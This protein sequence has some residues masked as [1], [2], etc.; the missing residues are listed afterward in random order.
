MNQSRDHCAYVC[1]RTHTHVRVYRAVSACVRRDMRDRIY[2]REVSDS[3][4]G[5]RCNI[6]STV[7]ALD[8]AALVLKH[9]CSDRVETD[10]CFAVTSDS[11]RLSRNSRDNRETRMA[12]LTH[13]GTVDTGA[14]AVCRWINP[15]IPSPLMNRMQMFVRAILQYIIII[16]PIYYNYNYSFVFK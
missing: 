6:V 5:S 4:D 11:S 8:V 12:I 15:S 2:V 16:I 1:T 3:G 9:A 14:P 7:H 13:A 10:G